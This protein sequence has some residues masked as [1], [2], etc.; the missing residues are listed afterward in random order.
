MLA[1]VGSASAS[2]QSTVQTDNPIAYFAL[3]TLDPSGAGTASDLSGNGNNAPYINV[4]SITGP[5]PYISNAGQFDPTSG[6]SVNLPAAGIL[7]FSGNITM[8]AWV[9]STNI[10]QGPSDIV[11]KGYDS[12]QNYDELC[13]RANGGVNYF[14]GTYN[15]S[16]G[17]A[18]ASGGQ[19]TT[20][21]TYLVSTYDGTNWNLYINSQLVN[22]G[23][24]AVGAINFSTPWAIGTGSADGASRFFQGNICQVALYT[25]AL[26]PAQVL[27]HF[28]V[29]EIGTPASSSVPI[30]TVQPKPQ[31]AAFG[32]TANFS[33]TTVRLF[34]DV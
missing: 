20:N 34:S 28:Y 4:F 30:I 12:S 2:Y 7:N 33:V 25:N 13:L 18:N 31:T 21:W 27:N 15:N 22:Q 16:N 1:A 24:D 17:G 19:Q 29:G 32:G 6:S 5:T 11:A 9:Q 10:T 8:E 14:G 26:T 23:A 3:D